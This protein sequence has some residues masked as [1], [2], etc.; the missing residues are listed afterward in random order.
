MSLY[1]VQKLIYELNR[2]AE[3]RKR[4]EADRD[5]SIRQYDLTDEERRIVDEQNV[6]Q[7]QDARQP[8]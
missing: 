1:H 4:F 6:P 8:Q 7:S 2:D 3:A 5:A